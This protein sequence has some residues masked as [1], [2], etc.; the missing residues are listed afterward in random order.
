M[1]EDWP[2]NQLFLAWLSRSY[3]FVL[4]PIRKSLLTNDFTPVDN[5]QSSED[6]R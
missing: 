4:R 2:V 6:L 1:S 5:Y 3:G